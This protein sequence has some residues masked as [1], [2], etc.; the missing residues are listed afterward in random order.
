MEFVRQGPDVR[1]SSLS[2]LRESA[3]SKCATPARSLQELSL[4]RVSQDVEQPGT[5]GFRT[6]CHLED[7]QRRKSFA[8]PISV[9]SE[10]TT[11]AIGSATIPVSPRLSRKVLF[12][13]TCHAD[14]KQV[15]VTA[16]IR[17]GQI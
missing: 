15:F 9:R 13:A 12:P 2:H 16:P 1:P 4:G 11:G 10:A 7:Q 5:Q 6:I 3:A 17:Q 14:H 8:R